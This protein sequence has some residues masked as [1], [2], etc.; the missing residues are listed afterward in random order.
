MYKYKPTMFKDFEIDQ[1][2]ISILDTLISMNNLNILFVGD[3]GSGKTS[4]INALIKEYYNGI[5][6][7][8]NIL[9]IN[10][11][12]EQGIQYYRTEVKTFCQTRC[13]IPNK[14][15]IVNKFLEIVLINIVTMFILYHHVLIFK[16]L[17]IVYSLEKLLSK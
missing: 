3:S 17:L 7:S 9:I 15:K 11:L 1:N 12:K 5:S 10:S 8:D 6:Y 16:R 2:I 14:K 13:S 4:L